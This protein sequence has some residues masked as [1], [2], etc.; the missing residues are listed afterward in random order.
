MERWVMV[1]TDKRGVFAGKI[2]A[3]DAP[4]SVVLEECRM[5]VYWDTGVRG[6]LGL[7][8]DGPNSTCRITKAAPQS[9][10]YGVT[11]VN[12]MS[13]KAVQAWRAEPWR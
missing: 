5:C 1:T 3:D 2:V 6:V 10:L 7:A 4:Q 13:D 12:T 11:S 9:T 8:A